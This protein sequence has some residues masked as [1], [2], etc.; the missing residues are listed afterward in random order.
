AVRPGRRHL[1]SM[2]VVALPLK[3]VM[4]AHNDTNA[5]REVEGKVER[6]GLCGDVFLASTRTGA[7]MT[8]VKIE[9]SVRQGEIT[10]DTGLQD[11][12]LEARYTLR[13]EI[14]ENGRRVRAFTSP[15]VRR[16]NCREGRYSFRE[17]WMPP[18]PWD[19]HT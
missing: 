12:A 1:L 10:V 2:L 3:A 19:R 16:I 14:R 15:V 11:L 4:L 13:A 17:K 18:K 5:P 7:R 9:T 6:R 8:D